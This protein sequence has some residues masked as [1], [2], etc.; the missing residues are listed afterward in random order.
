MFVS[1]TRSILCERLLFTLGKPFDSCVL[2][3]FIVSSGGPF[4]WNAVGHH[5]LDF[6]IQCG[7]EHLDRCV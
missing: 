1:L 6:I 3:G 5:L 4:Q 2:P 7:P